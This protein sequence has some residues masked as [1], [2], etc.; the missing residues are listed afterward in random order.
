MTTP[1]NFSSDYTFGAHPAVLKALMDTNELR[2]PGYGTDDLCEKARSAIR[3]A[4]ACRDAEVHFFSGGTQANA[5]V[6]TAALRHDQGVLSAD[7]GHVNLHEAGSIEA[8][9]HRVLTVP[10]EN[11]K[12]TAAAVQAFLTA[13]YA[14]ENHA[15]M[16]CPGIVYIS[17][18]TEYG[19]LYSLKELRALSAVC[20]AYGLPL[21]LDGARLAYALG[22]R[23]NDVTLPDIAACC[24]AFY[25]GGTNCGALFGEA[26]VLVNKALFPRFFTVVKQRGALLAKGRVLGVQFSALFTDGLYESIGKTAVAAADGLRKLFREKGYPLFMEN[27]TNQ[28]FVAFPDEKIKTLRPE[29]SFGFWEKYDDAHTVVRFA[30]DWATDQAMLDA[31]REL[32]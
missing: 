27:P 22:S 1:L 4:C 11:G 12:L 30:A 26:V 9:G 7:T 28:V 14:D 19:T 18:P 29:V 21:Y 20:K 24:D 8:G 16:V 23:E 17:Q 15:H 25:I 3:E 2:T 31:L 10:H 5:T 13:F 32:L 6:I